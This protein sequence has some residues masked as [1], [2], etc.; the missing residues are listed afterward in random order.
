MSYG[1]EPPFRTHQVG[2]CLYIYG[3]VD[4]VVIEQLQAAL[5]QPQIRIVNLA[6]VTFMDSIALRTLVQEKVRRAASEQ[7]LI[8]DEPSAP[9]RR[10]FELAG[11]VE[12]MLDRSD[13][14]P[15]DRSSDGATERERSFHRLDSRGRTER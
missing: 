6:D 7:P 11:L 1:S 8:V 9:V 14:C 2:R 5:Q 3:D 15:P 4:V 13:Q 10:L 12:S